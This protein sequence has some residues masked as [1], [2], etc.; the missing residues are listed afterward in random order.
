VLLAEEYMS[1]WPYIS[2]AYT[3][4]KRLPE[5]V[6]GTATSHYWCRLWSSNIRKS[7]GIG[8]RGKTIC[9]GVGFGFKLKDIIDVATGNHTL[10]RHGDCNS[11]CHT[12][13]FLDSVKR[14]EA[15]RK[16]AGAEVAHSYPVAVVTQTLR[17]PHRLNVE[18]I[19]QEAGGRFFSRQ[20]AHNTGA[21]YKAANPDS[22]FVRAE[23]TWEEQ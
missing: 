5:T 19:W 20:D 13:D 18:Q 15:L 8:K 12:L 4:N 22:R 3:L 23:A 7:E 6:A 16:I 9:V 11:H 10:S 1:Y 21:S 17:A 2:S 14:P